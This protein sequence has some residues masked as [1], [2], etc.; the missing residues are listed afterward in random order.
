MK[1]AF[2]P[3]PMN[4]TFEH[5]LS[6]MPLRRAPVDWRQAILRKAHAI[7]KAPPE[8]S[9]NRISKNWMALAAVW[10]LIALLRWD[11]TEEST[12][13]TAPLPEGFYVPCLSAFRSP[14][15]YLEAL[16]AEPPSPPPTP[17]QSRRTTR[18]NAFTA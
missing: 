15:V 17:K 9:S 10:T 11:S 14:E 5:R 1:S 7:R 3:K 8:P 16:L 13:G 18:E 2:K 6:Q 4:K 12:S